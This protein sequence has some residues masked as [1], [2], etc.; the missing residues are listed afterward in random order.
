MNSPRE[1]AYA[2]EQKLEECYSFRCE[3]CSKA[4][5]NSLSLMV[6][7]EHVVSC[8]K[9]REKRPDLHTEMVEISKARE[10]FSIKWYV[11]KGNMHPLSPFFAEESLHW[12]RQ[13]ERKKNSSTQILP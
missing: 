5:P 7:L 6:N 8:D 3:F 2:K 13:K 9:L 12:T 1:K 10:Q 4:L 11:L